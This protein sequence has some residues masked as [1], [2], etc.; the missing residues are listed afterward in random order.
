M[1]FKMSQTKFFLRFGTIYSFAE[2]SI[3]PFIKI[4]AFFCQ[5]SSYDHFCSQRCQV[6]TLLTVMTSS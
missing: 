6:K 1:L 4:S 3:W 2:F 5:F